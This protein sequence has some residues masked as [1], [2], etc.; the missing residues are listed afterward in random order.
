MAPVPPGASL[1][2]CRSWAGRA[3]ARVLAL[4]TGREFWCSDAGGRWRCA[5][6]ASS[7][8]N[9]GSLGRQSGPSPPPDCAERAQKTPSRWASTPG[10]GITRAYR[11]SS[12]LERVA[13]GLGAQRWGAGHPPPKSSG[14]DI[15]ARVAAI[16]SS[17]MSSAPSH[18]RPNRRPNRERRRESSW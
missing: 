13:L 7:G 8:E 14:H 9:S 12:M 4:T 18:H 5:S 15:P 11:G 6:A 1:Q 3:S 10:E 16:S 17:P 2:A